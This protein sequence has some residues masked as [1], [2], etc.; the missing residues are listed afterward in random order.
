MVN[1]GSETTRKIEDYKLSRYA[2]YLISQNGESANDK[3]KRNNVDNEY[4]ANSV[5]Y[6]IGKK[7]RKAIKD[8]E[9]IM[10]E[11]LP[12]PSINLKEIEHNKKNND[13]D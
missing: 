4:T 11:D 13:L 8:M 12:T 1:I 9:G 5:H 3:L 2:C 7:V 10:P 6:E